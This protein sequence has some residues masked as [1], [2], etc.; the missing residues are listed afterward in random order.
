MVQKSRSPD[1]LALGLGST[2]AWCDRGSPHE[3]PAPRRRSAGAARALGS[4]VG[5]HPVD[6]LAEGRFGLFG[7]NV[8]WSEA[9]DCK[10]ASEI[11]ALV[12]IPLVANAH[13]F[14]V[15]PGDRLSL[16][17]GG[18]QPCQRLCLPT[19]SIR[20]FLVGLEQPDLKRLRCC[21]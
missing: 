19:L 4:M 18:L 6:S 21:H 3:K 16:R 15:N 17:F 13:P 9:K 1:L 10:G 7:S 14:Q 5:T 20:G 12:K 11:L 8:V 2:K